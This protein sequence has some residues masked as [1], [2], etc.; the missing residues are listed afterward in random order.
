MLYF[1]PQ[2]NSKL[3]KTFSNNWKKKKSVDIFSLFKTN[4]KQIMNI[5]NRFAKEKYT[6]IDIDLLYPPNISS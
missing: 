1:F 5:A 4:K 2:H 3:K 6:Y